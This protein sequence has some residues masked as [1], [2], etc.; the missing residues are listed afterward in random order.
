MQKQTRMFSKGIINS[1]CKWN[2]LKMLIRNLD[3]INKKHVLSSNTLN[4]I[5][6]KTIPDV[7]PLS[8]PSKKIYGLK[9]II[10]CPEMLC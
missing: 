2:V 6:I 3:L 8:T 1:E 10:D 4:G 9:N 5:T 7:K